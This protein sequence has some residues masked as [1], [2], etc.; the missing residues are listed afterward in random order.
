MLL[1]HL[2]LLCHLYRWFSSSVLL[3]CLPL[4]CASLLVLPTLL[5]N[6]PYKYYTLASPSACMSVLSMLFLSTAPHMVASV[7]CMPSYPVL[8]ILSSSASVSPSCSTPAAY[9][10]ACMSPPSTVFPSPAPYMAASVYCMPSYPVLYILLTSTTASPF[11]PHLQLISVLV[12]H[13]HLPFSPPQPWVT[14]PLL[15]TPPPPSLYF[16]SI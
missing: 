12:C 16:L 9:T 2:Q 13:P 8:C 15:C 14:P 6:F 4:M 3:V 7:C 10:N 11:L 1:L 5:W